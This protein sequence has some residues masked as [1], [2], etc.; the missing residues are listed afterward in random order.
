M[1][2][3]TTRTNPSA[4]GPSTR[5]FGISSMSKNYSR[6]AAA[7]QIETIYQSISDSNAYRVYINAANGPPEGGP[8][9]YAKQYVGA[10]FSR[11]RLVTGDSRLLGRFRRDVAPL[12]FHPLHHL[13]HVVGK[14]QSIFHET[15]FDL[16]GGCEVRLA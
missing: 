2:V 3:T 9:E 5:T 15:L 16:T 7:S 1:T 8:H 10:G 11:T 6:L 14:K 13:R 12:L 4:W